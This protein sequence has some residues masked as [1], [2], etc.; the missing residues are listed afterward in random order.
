MRREHA[1]ERESQLA[2]IEQFSGRKI[3]PLISILIIIIRPWQGSLTIAPSAFVF[4]H[5]WSLILKLHSTFT[6]APFSE[7]SWPCWKDWNFGYHDE[8]IMSVGH[9]VMMWL[10]RLC[11][12]HFHCK[13]LLFTVLSVVI[14]TSSCKHFRVMNL[15]WFWDLAQLGFDSWMK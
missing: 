3:M 4:S 1:G 9:A 7:D 8:L 5:H 2:E 11:S 14:V 12:E 10:L 15:S 13:S 6:K